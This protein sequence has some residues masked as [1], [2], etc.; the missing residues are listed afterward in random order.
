MLVSNSNVHGAR[1]SFVGAGDSNFVQGNEINRGSTMPREI[2][3]L[4]LGIE[5][6]SAAGKFTIVMEILER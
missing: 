3:F 2:Y 4:R 6:S 1:M 5:A